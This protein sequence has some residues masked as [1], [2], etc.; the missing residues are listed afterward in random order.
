MP[1][2]PA[3]TV[4]AVIP[5]AGR[6][7]RLRSK[8]PKPLVLVAGLP[9]FIHTVLS[10]KKA[11]PFREILVAVHPLS[12]ARAA[13]WLKRLRLSQ[14]RLVNGGRTRA[15]SVRNAVKSV[16]DRCEWVLIHD[17]AR[18][19]V[20]RT[21]VRRLLNAA[22]PS[23]AA[24]C[25]VPVTATVKRVDLRQ[26]I[27]VKTEDRSVLFL[28]QTP[29]VFKRSL[30]LARYRRLGDRALERTDEAALFDGTGL[31][32]KVVDGSEKNLKVTTPHDLE[33]L[34]HYLVKPQ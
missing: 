3:E 27:V 6:G 20:D 9:L 11:F 30:L 22:R 19:L 29:Q 15:A 17:A 33:L 13:A 24:L 21:L 7:A 8:C 25:A 23:G 18:P 32:V 26:K 28:A 16:S 4:A 31:K 5:S 14:V 10:I 1:S 2:K 12:R 34:G